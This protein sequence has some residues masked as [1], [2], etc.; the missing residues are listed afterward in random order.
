MMPMRMGKI[1]ICHLEEKALWKIAKPVANGNKTSQSTKSYPY[2]CPFQL[3]K[4]RNLDFL[5]NDENIIYSLQ[6]P[7]SSSRGE[8]SGVKYSTQ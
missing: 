8:T 2:T 3:I 4:L 6:I 5:Q 1:A 7:I